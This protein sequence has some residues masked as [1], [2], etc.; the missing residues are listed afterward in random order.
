MTNRQIASDLG[1]DL[2][3]G[4]HFRRELAA[5]LAVSVGYGADLVNDIAANR[6]GLSTCTGCGDL[7][8]CTAHSCGVCGWEYSGVIN[9][10]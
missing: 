6:V 3:R 2:G 4:E 5:E 9:G 1:D 7:I 10:Y 8:D